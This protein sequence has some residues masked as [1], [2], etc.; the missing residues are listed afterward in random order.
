MQKNK[1]RG[2]ADRRK[3]RLYMTKDETSSLTVSTEALLVTCLINATEERD[4]ATVHIPGAFMQSDMEG[5][6]TFMKIEG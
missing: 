4:V 6:D 1:G 3:Q 2:Y 5:E